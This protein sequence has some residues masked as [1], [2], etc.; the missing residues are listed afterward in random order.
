M[1]T[2]LNIKSTVLLF[3]IF[4]LQQNIAA[5]SD[6]VQTLPTKQH[7]VTFA[8]QVRPRAEIRYGNFQPMPANQKIAALISQRT[9][10]SFNYQYKQL[11]SLQITPQS[12]TIW[13]QENL[14]Q[15]TVTKNSLA[16]FEAWFKLYAG[17]AVSFTVG[18]QVI[19][20]DDERFFGELDWAQ[21]ARAH[22]AVSFQFEKP[23]GALRV[24]AAYNQNYKAIYGNNLSNVSGNLFSP[25]DA[26]P[27]KWMQTAWGRYN[28]HTQHA[29]SALVTNLGFQDAKDAADSA[30]TYFTQVLG[31]NYFYTGAH[32]QFTAS[33]YYQMGKNPQGKN[34]SAYLA[35]INLNRKIGKQWNIGIGG[36]LV[37]GNDVGTGNSSINKAFVPFFG[38][39][40][41]FY[42]SMD[43][44]YAGNAHKNSGLVDAYFKTNYHPSKKVSLALAFHQFTSPNKLE[45]AGKT[46]ASN[47]GQE[48]DLDCAYNIHKFVKLIGGYSM[49]VATPSTNFLKNVTPSNPLQHWVGLSINV[50]ANFLNMKF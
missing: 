9:R 12:V 34:T 44:Y 29:I 6:S 49:Y 36:D 11:L 42:G 22:D 15:G 13:G 30:K 27:Y 1:N 39:N 17:S 20:L 47:L 33:G 23:Q 32:W 18:R 41:K 5:Q 26:A 40:H 45:D 43:Y 10:L 3:L 28:V 21:G 24:Y 14:T 2:H 4:C 16:L 38:T 50:N 35:A 37:S 8:A 19:S 31:L 7:Q 48:I 46:L 25:I